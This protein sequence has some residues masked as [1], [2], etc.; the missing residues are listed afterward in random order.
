V[1]A[2]TG[3]RLVQAVPAGLSLAPDGRV[4]V[5]LLG[6]APFGADFRAKASGRILRYGT[7][8]GAQA[9]T[10]ADGL[11]RPTGFA[12]LGDGR[13]VVAEEGT[14]RLRTVGGN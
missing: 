3:G 12:L 4:L 11:A 1:T 10:L 9:R 6:G 8:A 5:A 7:A 14:G 2:G 13:F